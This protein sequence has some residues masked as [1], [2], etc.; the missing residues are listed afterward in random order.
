MS[1]TSGQMENPVSVLYFIGYLSCQFN[2][3]NCQLYQLDLFHVTE[4]KYSHDYKGILKLNTVAK[5]PPLHLILWNASWQLNE[6]FCSQF[7][8]YKT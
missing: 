2:M 7:Y 1:N 6:N 4:T 5:I 3:P 8:Y